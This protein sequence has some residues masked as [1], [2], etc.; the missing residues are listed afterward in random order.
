[1][2][3]LQTDFRRDR[4]TSPVDIDET[5]PRRISLEF[6][7]GRSGVY[8]FNLNCSSAF[9]DPVYSL[10]NG[11]NVSNIVTYIRNVRFLYSDCIETF[12]SNYDA[13][14]AISINGKRCI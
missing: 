2:I 13:Q 8:Q 1:M 6:R 10:S 4:E 14:A 11:Q 5:L 9:A 7:C 3:S 12:P